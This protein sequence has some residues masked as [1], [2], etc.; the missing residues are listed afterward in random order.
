MDGVASGPAEIFGYQTG[1]QSDGARNA[2]SRHWCPFADSICTKQSRLLD[3]PFGVCS[4][5][6]RD[7]ICAV[8]PR[9]FE[10]RGS[11]EGVSSV[12]ADIA[13]HYFGDL[14]N[15]IPFSEVKL[16]NVGAIDYVLVRHKPMKAEVDD[17]I[18][19]EFQSDS[20][21]STGGLVQAMR[22]FSWGEDVEGQTYRFGMNTY[23][24]V[25][26]MITQLLN[27][28]IVYEKWNTKC[29]WVFQEYIYSNLVNRYGC[30]KDGYSPEHASRFA[31]YNLVQEGDRLVLRPSRFIS[32]TT[33]EIYQAMRNNPNL[34]DKDRFVKALE[35][36]LQ[37]RLSLKLS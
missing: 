29:Y 20:T 15:V 14:T 8:C 19:V 16:P 22:D 3:Y 6:R 12:I 2:R 10:E 1:N 30:K 27:K 34:P 21:T 18:A 7:E 9:R 23:D 37:A 26:R 32:T 13:L 36:K 31:P 24:S 25:K 35:T 33:D 11:M 17:L 4:V 5:K 28:G